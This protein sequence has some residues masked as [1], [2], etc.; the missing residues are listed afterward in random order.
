MYD[1]SAEPRE[2][3]ENVNHPIHIMGIKLGHFPYVFWSLIIPL[4]IAGPLF[5]FLMAFIVISISRYVFK[6]E[7]QGLPFLFCPKIR[8]QVDKLPKIIRRTV[9]SEIV[10]IER[11]YSNYRE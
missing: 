10:Q 3:V 5:A 8:S 6:S 9:F 2:P 4:I 7:Q 11:S 1:Y